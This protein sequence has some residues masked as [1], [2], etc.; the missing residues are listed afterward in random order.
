MESGSLIAR[1]TLEFPEI[2][3]PGKQGDVPNARIELYTGF[4]EDECVW[5][6]VSYT[7]HLEF[8]QP[9]KVDVFPALDSPEICWAI[10]SSGW[11]RQEGWMQRKLVV[12]RAQSGS[13]NTELSPAH[14]L[15]LQH[16]SRVTGMLAN[17]KGDYGLSRI[18]SHRVNGLINAQN[19]FWRSMTSI[20]V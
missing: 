18:L 14:P 13:R 8:L 11:R 17:Q 3:W 12:C 16:L 20:P 6:G 10:A 7:S 4:V 1:V 15:V 19:R 9:I 2:P 5:G